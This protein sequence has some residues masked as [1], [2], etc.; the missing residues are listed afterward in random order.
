LP[1][2]RLHV[3]EVFV[4]YSS[5]RYLDAKIRTWV[6]FLRE[7]LPLAF[8]R[9]RAIL[10]DRRDWAESPTGVARETAT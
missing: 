3:R 10:D 8:E 2:H 6:D 7:R 5:R 9:D 4:L 1:G